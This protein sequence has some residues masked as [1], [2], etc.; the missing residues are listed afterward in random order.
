MSAPADGLDH[1]TRATR[2]LGNTERSE[3]HDKALWFVRTKRDRATT[4]IPEWEEL[5]MQASRIKAHTVSNLDTLLE[6]FES[7]CR[8]NGVTVHWAADAADHNRIV[9]ALLA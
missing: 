6:R 8:A 9:H 2:F 3:R 5:R 1:A 7:A 4:L